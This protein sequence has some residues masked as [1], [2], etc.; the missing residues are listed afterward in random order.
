[1]R[2]RQLCMSLR[3][4]PSTNNRE[5][6]LKN[7]ESSL[8]PWQ[9]YQEM[10]KIHPFTIV[11]VYEYQLD[12][13]FYI[14]EYRNNDSAASAHQRVRNS[15]RKFGE[16]AHISW[17][18]AENILSRASG[19]FCF[20][21]EVSQNRTQREVSQNRTRRVPPRQRAVSSFKWKWYQV[22]Y[23][24]GSCYQIHKAPNVLFVLHV[25]RTKMHK[26]L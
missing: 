2:F 22:C 24:I 8:R 15:I 25:S 20:Q 5:L 6:V 17:L 11:R 19:S 26:I 21:R 12:Q 9:V 16:H 1:M 10:L 23:F 14:F 7:V 4:E 18:T 13:F 3:V